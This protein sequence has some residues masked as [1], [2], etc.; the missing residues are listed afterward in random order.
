MFDSLDESEM[1]YLFGSISCMIECGLF[2]VYWGV[3]FYG[4]MI[5]VLCDS[6]SWVFVLVSFCV[7]SFWYVMLFVLIVN[8]VVFM[9]YFCMMY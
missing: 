4:L 5:M 9:F 7:I 8:V 1:F 3:C 2:F 6:D